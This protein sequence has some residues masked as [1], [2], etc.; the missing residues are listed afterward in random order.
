M[1][2]FGHIGDGNVHANF[3]ISGLDPDELKRTEKA[4]E[5]VFDLAL[6]Y[7]GSI[8]GEH[9]VGITKASFMK[10]MFK[11]KEIEIMRGIKSVFDPEGLINPGKMGL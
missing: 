8:T 6:K 7:G 5:E 9:G 2:N 11:P 3:M 10:K 1:V 4:V